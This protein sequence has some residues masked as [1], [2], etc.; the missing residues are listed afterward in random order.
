MLINSYY[1]EKLDRVRLKSSKGAF[2]T[3]IK[4]ASI[5]INATINV[6][7]EPLRKKVRRFPI[8]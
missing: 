3:W 8:T 4:L 6:E 2:S 5:H 1:V 7:E